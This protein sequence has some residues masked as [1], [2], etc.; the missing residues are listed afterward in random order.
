M[1][2]F[3][4]WVGVLEIYWLDHCVLYYSLSRLHIIKK[5]Q[6]STFHRITILIFISVYFT[7]LISS[8]A[9][10]VEG[11]VRIVVGD[12]YESYE[13]ATDIDSSYFI[14]DELSRGRVEVCVGG[15]FGTVCDDSWDNQDASVVCQQLG[16]SRIGEIPYFIN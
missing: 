3:V 15:E 2:V 5:T 9:S 13:T 8:L 1:I 12:D 14:K 7:V 16:F 11:A 6:L 10:C 4:D